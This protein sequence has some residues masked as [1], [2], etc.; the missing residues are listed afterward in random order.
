MNP[1]H[2]KRFVYRQ[3][4]E[5]ALLGVSKWL[6]EV[7]SVDAKLTPNVLEGHAKFAL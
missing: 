7:D 2:V 5:N 4:L 3:T 6:R 1:R